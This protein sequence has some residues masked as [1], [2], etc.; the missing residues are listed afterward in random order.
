M[1]LLDFDPAAY[2]VEVTF[3]PDKAKREYD[4][5]VTHIGERISDAVRYIDGVA[6]VRI[7]HPIAVSK[8]ERD[9]E[10]LVTAIQKALNSRASMG[11][12]DIETLTKAL[13]TVG[14]R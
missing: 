6:F 8:A 2:R 3:N 4:D 10:T 9:R 7:D 11:I 14:V 5:L 13:S 12:D 1:G